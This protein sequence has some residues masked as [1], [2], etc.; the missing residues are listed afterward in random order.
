MR[1]IHRSILVFAPLV[2][3]SFATSPRSQEGAPQRQRTP[4]QA[5]P[6]RWNAIG[7]QL[8]TTAEDW[9][10]DKYAHRLNAEVRAF[11][12]VLLHAA[13][14]NYELLN[15]LSGR[16][17]GDERN[18][19][20]VTDY[21]TKGQTVAFLKKSAAHGAAEMQREGD[22][23]VVMHLYDWLGYTEPMG[24]QLWLAGRLLPEQRHRAAR[25]SRNTM[26]FTELTKICR[27]ARGS[28]LVS[29]RSA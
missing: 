18:D 17:L 3:L 2:A 15:H 10:A 16:K 6:A 23:G 24:E 8:I 14:T 7:K 27:R 1:K 19:P 22:A 4:T 28:L 12:Q 20:A 21:Q 25:V 5:A 13:G 9:S 26:R 29:P 11:Q